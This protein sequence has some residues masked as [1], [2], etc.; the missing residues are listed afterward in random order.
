[1]TDI[2]KRIERFT[3]SYVSESVRDNPNGKD[4]FDLKFEHTDRVRNNSLLLSKRL[5]FDKSEIHISELIGLLHD[6]GRFKQYR[7]FKSFSDAETGSHATHS[8]QMI[9]EHDLLSGLSL[10]D[11]ELIKLAIEYHNHYHVPKD[12]TG[13]LKKFSTLIRDADKL[14]AFFL[15]T[16]KND[17]RQYNLEKLLDDRNYSDEVIDDLMNLRQVDFSNFKYK[18]DRT[19]GILGLIFNLEYKESLEILKE[20]NYIDRIIDSIPSS[21]ELEEVRKRTKAYVDKKISHH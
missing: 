21:D 4:N 19:L 15:E 5:S 10:E 18:H 13:R 2:L 6:I 1:M 16:C 20:N 17:E 14:D 8:V 9:E 3:E 12:V 7:L 11:I